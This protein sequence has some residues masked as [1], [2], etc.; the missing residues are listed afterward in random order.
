VLLP[1]KHAH[2]DATVL[3]AATVALNA[4]RNKRVLSFDE[5]KSTIEK[6]TRSADYLFTP[7]VSV[8]FLLGL[9]EYRPTVDAFEYVGANS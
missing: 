2:P 5:L 8:L 7:A 9:I 6:K 4:L 1:S 3:A